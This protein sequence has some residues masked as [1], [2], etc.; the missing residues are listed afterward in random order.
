MNSQSFTYILFL[1]AVFSISV[2]SCERH[3]LDE[4]VHKNDPSKEGDGYIPSAI[5]VTNMQFHTGGGLGGYF[6][7]FGENNRFET[8]GFCDI[9]PGSGTIGTYTQKS[10]V[11]YMVDS[12]CFENRPHFTDERKYIDCTG[13]TMSVYYLV[14]TKSNIYLTKNA[15][16]TLDPTSAHIDG[17]NP[18]CELLGIE[19]RLK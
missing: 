9:C 4:Q 8:F 11:V 3:S 7:T 5:D 17:S 16:D 18:R 2:S 19:R 6:I 13:P 15:N 1:L 12:L 10:K 14:Q